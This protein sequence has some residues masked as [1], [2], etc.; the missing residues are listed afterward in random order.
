[1]KKIIISAIILLFY[2]T[3]TEA[4]VK[5][6]I[7]YDNK[8][9]DLCGNLLDPLYNNTGNSEW[10]DYAAIWEIERDVLCLLGLDNS[11]SV[12]SPDY[13]KAD[14]K[15]LF[16]ERY[17][18]GKVKAVW[19]TGDL[20]VPD[21]RVFLQVNNEYIY[22]RDIIISVD[23]GKITNKIVIDNTKK[24]DLSEKRSMLIPIIEP[25]KSLFG[26]P[27]GT[28]EDEFIARFG[29][30]MRSNRSGKT[31]REMM[32]GKK[33]IF[34][35]EKTKLAGM[36]TIYSEHEVYQIIPTHNT[37]DYLEWKLSNGITKN[38]NLA[39][40]KKILGNNAGEFENK[41]IP[42][43]YFTT[44]KARIEISLRHEAERENTDEAY[45]VSEISVKLK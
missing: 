45:I 15:E 4:E 11:I 5:N 1:M 21:G 22:E 30:P 3:I 10:C 40:V 27:Y 9:F 7:L 26:I 37:F 8:V 24:K 32:Y 2:S 28:G 14:M 42:K 38:M 35:F 39:E 18:D 16:G 34:V 44:V 6:K 31:G 20:R 23:A 13:K 41:G 17:R 19:F 43:F 33:Y 25:D 36:K 12:G 29:Q